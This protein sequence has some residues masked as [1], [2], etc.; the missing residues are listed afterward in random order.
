[1]DA[2]Q[3]TLHHHSVLGKLRSV[4]TFGWGNGILAHDGRKQSHFGDPERGNVVGRISYGL[5]HP[6][7]SSHGVSSWRVMW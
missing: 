7:P 2:A 3:G 1:M 4:D 6:P 5:V